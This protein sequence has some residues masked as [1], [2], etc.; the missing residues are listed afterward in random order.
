[1]LE[2]DHASLGDPEAGGTEFS[3]TAVE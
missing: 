1:T 3:M 2:P